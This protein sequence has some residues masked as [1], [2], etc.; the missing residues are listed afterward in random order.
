MN[1]LFQAKS[2]MASKYELMSAQ[3]PHAE[4]TARFERIFKAA[5]STTFFILTN[6][7]TRFIKSK[8][9]KQGVA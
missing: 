8:F 7:L 2:V 9:R 5:T 3:Q 6:L 1:G 4:A